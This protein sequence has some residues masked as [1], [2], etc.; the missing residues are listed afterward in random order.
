MRERTSGAFTMNYN[1][2]ALYYGIYAANHVEIGTPFY[3]AMLQYIP[4]GRKDA[5]TQFQCPGINMD[6]EIFHWGQS[7]SG[8]GDQGQRS[9]AALAAVPIANHWLWTRDVDWLNATGWPYLDEIAQFWE[10]YLARGKDYPGTPNGSYSSVGDCLGELC[11]LTADFPGGYPNLHFDHEFVHVNPHISLAMLR[12]LFPVFIDATEALGIEPK[13]RALWKHLH[14]NLAPLVT[15]Q[16]VSNKTIFGNVLGS[17]SYSSNDPL[18]SYL[19]WPGY[20][21]ALTTNATLRQILKNTLDVLPQ[22]VGGN[23]WPQY[24][25]SRV[26][27]QD[28]PT[29]TNST[30]HTLI[31]IMAN[32]PTNGITG[33]P[34]G[35]APAMEGGGGIGIVNELLLQTF[36]GTIEL[37][38]QVP[39]GQPAA[40]TN[41][42]GRGAF[43]IS[44]SMAAGNRDQISNVTIVSEKGGMVNLRSPWALHPSISVVAVPSSRAATAVR[45]MGSNVFSWVSKPGTSYTVIPK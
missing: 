32:I 24:P 36:T 30:W 39:P 38:P 19:G 26:R 9:N 37:F 4:R 11:C 2:Q 27:L 15:V 17:E 43:L 44:A 23:S 41:L 33:D 7:V 40:F 20:D 45:N 31:A 25:P 34:P 35:A 12:F 42:R 3:N 14:S 8:L 1:Q 10:C 13:R 21:D 22:F 18:N 28:Y 5:H 29:Q 16:H 6:C